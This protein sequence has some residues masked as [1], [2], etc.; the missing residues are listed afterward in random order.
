[1][2]HDGGVGPDDICREVSQL[3]GAQ[4]SERR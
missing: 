2:V 3:P 1:V 4:W